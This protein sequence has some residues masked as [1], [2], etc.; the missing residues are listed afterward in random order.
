M[1]VE[2]FICIVSIKDNFTATRSLSSLNVENVFNGHG[3]GATVGTFHYFNSIKN[4]RDLGSL[5]V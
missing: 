4:M 2:E 5:R 3:D 1:L